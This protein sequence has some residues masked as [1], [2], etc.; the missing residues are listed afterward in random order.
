MRAGI[1]R[2]SD[3]GS[4]G[5]STK[6]ASWTPSTCMPATKRA[7]TRPRARTITTQTVPPCFVKRA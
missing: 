3:G 5:P 7:N 6:A 1:L 2:A 4:S